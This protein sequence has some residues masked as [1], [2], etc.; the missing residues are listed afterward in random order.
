[1]TPG[2]F[3]SLAD[4]GLT[5]GTPPEEQTSYTIAQLAEFIEFFEKTVDEIYAYILHCTRV[6][7]A[8][9]EL[10][11]TVYF[12]LLQR[13]R[14]FWWRTSASMAMVL[15]L[16]DK[17]MAALPA[18]Q[19][20]ATGY[21]YAEELL[22]CVQGSAE[23]QRMRH[24][25]QGLRKLPVRQQ[26]LAVLRF[27][28]RWNTTKIAAVFGKTK[29][30]VEKEVEQIGALLCE[31]LKAEERK[32]LGGLPAPEEACG[33]LTLI[34]CPALPP[35]RKSA[36]RMALLER[37]QTMPM[38][39]M[40]FAVPMGAAVLVLSIF[41]A[42]FLFPPP[43]ARSTFEQIAAIEVLLLGQ[44]MEARNAFVAAEQDL[45]GIAAFYAQEDALRISLRLAPLAAAAQV[46]E[47]KKITEILKLLGESALLQNPDL[48]SFGGIY[49]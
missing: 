31:E 15:A 25:L 2:S 40:R 1:M 18:W 48:V 47:E 7:D 11:L 34:R 41:L 33:V 42:T 8:A 9:A 10:T 43:T 37:C 4:R 26:R 22:R 46:E 13:R 16:A 28:L 5:P 36:F 45:R 20:Q 49:E 27:F 6:P 17:E 44:E 38:S 12:A 3:P 29:D 39:S 30:L 19:E 35:D 24:L 32:D 23:R 14:F 21:G